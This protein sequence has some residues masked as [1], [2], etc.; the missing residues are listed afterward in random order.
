VDGPADFVGLGVAPGVLEVFCDDLK[1]VFL[2]FFYV[3]L[4]AGPGTEVT[5]ELV[6]VVWFNYIDI[7]LFNLF[8]WKW[9]SAVLLVNIITLFVPVWMGD[10][11]VK[12]ID[13]LV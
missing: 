5:Y 2:F 1:W 10:V 9:Y 13:D 11:P 6:E 3:M 12:M 8:E 7:R 4:H